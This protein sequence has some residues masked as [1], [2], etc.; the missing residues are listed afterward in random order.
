MMN[1]SVTTRVLDSWPILEWL[2]GREPAHSLVAALFAKSEQGR[3]R[4]LISAIN[5]GEVYYCLCKGNKQAVAESWRESSA[6]LPATIE[7]PTADDIWTA[8]ELKGRYRI[9]YADAFAAALAQKYRC[10]L[11][12]GDPEFRSVG[13][14]QI[15]WIL[16]H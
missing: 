2:S 6:T 16:R 3:T 14:L 4:L 9:S 11:V 5:A 8:A 15:E 13:D 7:A 10:P 1:A 12:T